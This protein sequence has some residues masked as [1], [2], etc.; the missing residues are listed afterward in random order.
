[1]KLL[2]PFIGSMIVSSLLFI[3]CSQN[4]G[5]KFLGKYSM[6]ENSDV[7]VFIVI[8]SDNNTYTAKLVHR[9]STE[10]IFKYNIQTKN[11]ISLA[12]DTMSLNDKGELRFTNENGPKIFYKIK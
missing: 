12:N 11:L 10:Y 8:N 7:P 5:A 4:D 1:M 9:N 3:S 2:K 6:D